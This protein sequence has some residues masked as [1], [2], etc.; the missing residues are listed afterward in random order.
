MRISA[1]SFCVFPKVDRVEW[2]IYY[3]SCSCLFTLSCS[4]VTRGI[5]ELNI[6][7]I[8]SR[9]VLLV[10]KILNHC[11]SSSVS[12][13]G[14]PSEPHW[15]WPS[16][17]KTID[18]DS[19][20]E[21]LRSLFTSSIFFFRKTSRDIRPSSQNNSLLS[22]APGNLITPPTSSSPTINDRTWAL[23]IFHCWFVIKNG[24][25]KLY[26]RRG[27]CICSIFLI[28]SALWCGEIINVFVPHADHC[29]DLRTMIVSGW[30]SKSSI[31]FSAEEMLQIN[32]F[33]SCASVVGRNR[34]LLSARFL[35]V[36]PAIV[37]WSDALSWSNTLATHGS[38]MG[39]L[40]RITPSS[41]CSCT[42]WAME[43]S[44]H[45]CVLFTRNPNGL[46]SCLLIVVANVWIWFP[47][48]L[49]FSAYFFIKDRY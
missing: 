21:L 7:S 44:S 43:L 35:S 18:L 41:P 10:P 1:R 46:F 4:V 16:W 13:P 23:W 2:G 40:A 30:V 28:N 39:I 8:E 19:P 48:N 38:L 31:V 11:A 32:P 20:L 34:S 24:W 14:F 33:I 5:V 42:N 27:K 17:E 9:R 29:D 22:E 3:R 45:T 26:A 37:S 47:K 12:I 25:T 36:F 15:N 6:S 49:I